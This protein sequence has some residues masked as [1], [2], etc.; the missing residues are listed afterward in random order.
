VGSVFVV[1]SINMDVVATADRHPRSG[2]TVTGEELQFLPG[3]KGANQAVAAHR[4]QAET[5]LV[6]RLGEDHFADQLEAFLR[7]AG[8]N[9][10][11]VEREPKLPTGTAL[12]TVA[13]S[14]NTI[15]VVPGA[16]GALGPRDVQALPMAPGDVVVAQLEVPVETVEAALRHGRKEGATTVLNPSPVMPFSPELLGL[17]DVLVVNE[18]ELAFLGDAQTDASEGEGDIVGAARGLRARDSQVIVTTLGS[19]GAVAFDGDEVIRI[20]GRRVDAVDS[21][22]AGDCF[23]GNLAAE[24]SRK[25]PV[26]AALATAN[27]AASL[28]VQSFGAGPSMPRLAEVRAVI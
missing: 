8:L 27:V 7:D 3:G 19:D 12:V 15:V 4:A 20:E 17:A 11:Y 28:C 2:E 18:T 23:T 25:A 6:G 10:D 22:G 13:G 9:L 1:G 26:P 14:Q 5:R 24:L 21:T 16:N